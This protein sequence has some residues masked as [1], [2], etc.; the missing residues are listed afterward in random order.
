ML[1]ILGKFWRMVQGK[2]ESSETPVFPSA[3]VS[4]KHR[5]LYHSGQ[6]KLTVWKMAEQVSIAGFDCDEFQI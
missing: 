2:Q 3:V 1:G 6:K 5:S 4:A